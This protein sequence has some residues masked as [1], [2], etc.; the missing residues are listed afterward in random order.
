M[1]WFLDTTQAPVL[2]QCVKESLATKVIAAKPPADRVI[3]GY[4][5]KGKRKRYEK[6]EVGEA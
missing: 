5:R 3:K 6:G 4:K 1:R 2:Q